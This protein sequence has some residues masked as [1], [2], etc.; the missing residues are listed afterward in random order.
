[1]RNDYTKISGSA[2]S[3]EPELP[4]FLRSRMVN[5]DTVTSDLR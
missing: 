2:H 3:C 5:D 1:M 4:F